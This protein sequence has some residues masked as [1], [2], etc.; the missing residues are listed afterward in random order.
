MA[1]RFLIA[2]YSSESGLQTSIK[3]CFKYAFFSRI[4]LFSKG[5]I[6]KRRS[7]VIDIPLGSKF[8]DFTVLEFYGS[9][10]YRGAIWKCECICG[11]ICI[12]YGGS[13][14]N[15]SRVSC[16]C[17][18]ERR[19]LQTGINRIHS[20]Y[21]R[22]ALLRNKIFTLTKQ[23]V[24]ELILSNCHYCGKQPHQELKRLKT[25]KTQII[26]NG[27]DRYDPLKGYIK[28]N[29]VSCCY[30]CNHAKADLTFYEWKSHLEKIF[31]YQGISNGQ[32]SHSSI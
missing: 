12:I 19:I 13:L 26:Y 29:C 31:I 22:K 6:M 20:S 16:G 23:D 25:K 27:I 9:G 11:N 17:K 15:G 28:E 1:D 7:D 10:K 14:R 18:S 5:R 8:G 3:P 4:Y 24:K 32:I 30:Y 21:K 2:P